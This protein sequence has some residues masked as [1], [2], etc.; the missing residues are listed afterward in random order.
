MILGDVGREA[1][2]GDAFAAVLAVRDPGRDINL[3]HVSCNDTRRTGRFVVLPNWNSE[4]AQNQKTAG[5]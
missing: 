4:A 1:I 2:D 3:L 5:A